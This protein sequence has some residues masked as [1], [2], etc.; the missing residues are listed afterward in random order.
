MPLSFS[1]FC[2]SSSSNQLTNSFAAFRCPDLPAMP[3]QHARALSLPHS[4]LVAVNSSTLPCSMAILPFQV[5]LV[6]SSHVLGYSSGLTR[7]VL[8][9]GV[10]GLTRSVTQVP[11]G[12]LRLSG[13]FA[14][15]P[16]VYVA[17]KPL[18]TRRT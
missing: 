2:P 1:A 17:R 15:T 9:D 7:L 8:S 16:G 18:V 5:G 4:A 12:S 10:C 6:R 13:Y 11:L 3:F 14:A